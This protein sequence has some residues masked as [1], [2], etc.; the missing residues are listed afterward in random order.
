MYQVLTFPSYLGSPVKFK[1]YWTARVY[2]WLKSC[3]TVSEI[4]IIDSEGNH[5]KII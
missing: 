3:V 4:R 2:A 1:W 5:L